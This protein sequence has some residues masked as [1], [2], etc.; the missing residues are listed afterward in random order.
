MAYLY[1]GPTTQ[2]TFTA[3]VGGATPVATLGRAEFSS[4]AQGFSTLLAVSRG[5]NDLATFN[6]ND[7]SSAVD[8]FFA[9]GDVASLSVRPR[10]RIWPIRRWVSAT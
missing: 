1:D 10:I 7:S 2:D 9:E 4:Q 3:S 8:E 5:G 6:D